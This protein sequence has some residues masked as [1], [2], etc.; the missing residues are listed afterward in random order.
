MSVVGSIL[1]IL[2]RLFCILLMR[3]SVVCVFR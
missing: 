2:C 3:L 1:V